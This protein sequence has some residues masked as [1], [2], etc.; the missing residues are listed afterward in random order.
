MGATRLCRYR[1]SANLLL[2][3]EYA[4]TEP[5]GLGVACA[6]DRYLDC[7]IEPAEAFSYIGI[8]PAATLHCRLL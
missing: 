3:G 7:R 2:C 6:L 4:I 1:V 5:G 8:T